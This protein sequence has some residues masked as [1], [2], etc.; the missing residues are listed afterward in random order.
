MLVAFL[1]VMGVLAGVLG[2][3]VHAAHDDLERTARELDRVRVDND[4]ILRQ[5]AT[6]VLTV[7]AW[8]TIAYLN[9]AAEH[10]LGLRLVDLRGRLMDEALPERLSLLRD[11]VGESL[12]R[13]Q[14]RTRV[15]LAARGVQGEVLSLGLTTNLLR[16]EGAVTGVVAVFQDLT[17]VRAMERRA[18]RNE[19]LAEVGALA[20]GIAHELRNGLNPISGSVE[21]LQRELKPEGESAVLMALIVKECG[22]LNRFVTDL[23]N[24]ARE[25]DLVLEPLDLDEHLAEL[26]D[27]LQRDPRCASGVRV[28][29]EPPGLP[30]RVRADREQL[31]QVW[32][33]L[34]NNAM[35]AMADHGTLTVRWRPVDDETA[36]VEFADQGAGMAPEVL[37]RV[38]E[39][40]FTTK[41]EGTGLGVAIAQRIVERHGGALSFESSPGRGTVARVR[42]PAEIGTLA[43][44]A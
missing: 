7:D 31:R 24:Y 21:F 34:V 29:F 9:P 2:R 30:A 23:L 28:V 37:P 1:A 26:R 11:V 15:E 14:A 33:N 25:R 36:V 41:Q 13:G 10:L 6:G 32:L 12:R 8:G 16:H 44:A 18:R 27:G 19:T 17:E 35:D 3:R 42:L 40:F 5:L 39:P 43:K 38:G 4:V 22:R 20:A